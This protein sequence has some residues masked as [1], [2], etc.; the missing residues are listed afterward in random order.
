MR[1]VQFCLKNT[2]AFDLPRK[3]LCSVGFV[4]SFFV[5]L[6]GL[7]RLTTKITQQEFRDT[8]IAMFRL[9]NLSRPPI[10]F[11][12]NARLYRQTNVL[13]L[14]CKPWIKE[15]SLMNFIWQ[16]RPCTIYRLL[17]VTWL[18]TCWNVTSFEITD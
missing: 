3:L 16:T 17:Q 7:S 9:G 2:Y 4:V 6:K 12:P 11:S 13:W 8:T 1:I 14:F 10:F 5:W 18:K 15:K